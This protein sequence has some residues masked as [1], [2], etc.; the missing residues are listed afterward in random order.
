MDTS[1]QEQIKNLEQAAKD[2]RQVAEREEQAAK[3]RRQAAEREEQAAKDRRQAA[4][5]EEKVANLRQLERKKLEISINTNN[6]EFSTNGQ[7]AVPKLLE[8]VNRDPDLKYKP[9]KKGKYYQ[10]SNIKNKKEIVIE[11]SNIGRAEY[12]LITTSSPSS[13]INDLP[14]VKD[15]ERFGEKPSKRKQYDFKGKKIEEVIKMIK[16]LLA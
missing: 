9:Y 10:I 8:R 4:E 16:E 13:I 7:E 15:W 6:D 12:G 2:R 11:N 1:I 14:L 5:L 3:D